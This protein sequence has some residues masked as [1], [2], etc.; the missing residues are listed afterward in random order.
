[1]T[2]TDHVNLLRQAIPRSG[3]VWADL[4][5]GSGAFTLALR[6]LVG[7]DAQIYSIDR[8]G[9][10]LREQER[11]FRNRFGVSSLTNLH[12]VQ[13]DFTRSL[14]LAPLDGIVMANALHYF[15]DKEPVL[16][17]IRTLLKPGG[18]L[19][20]VEYNVDSGNPWVPHPLSFATFQTLAP[21]V[22]LAEPRLVATA[23]SSFLREFYSASAANPSFQNSPR[24]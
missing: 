20:L 14:G 7:A 5:S 17:H 1:M 12:L 9:A 22:G 15:R 19:V 10:R 4:G 18:I 2:H 13:A 6:E 24:A 3:G 23:P 21:R 11:V 16:R 8:D